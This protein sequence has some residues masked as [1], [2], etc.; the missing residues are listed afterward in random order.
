[1]PA[2]LP[3]GP[4]AAEVYDKASR[5]AA[6]LGDQVWPGYDFRKYARL[7]TDPATG[8]KAIRI[9]PAPKAERPDVL[10]TL[11]EAWLKKGTPEDNVLLAFHEGFH[12]FEHDPARPG[13]R[14]RFE[15]AFHLF[16]YAA[17]PARNSALFA[18]E[19]RLLHDA[20]LAESAEE[21]RKRARQ[22]LTVRGLRQK[23]LAAALVEFEKG[24]E[25]NE[26]MAEYAGARAVVDGMAAEK[27]KRIPATFSFTDGPR[28]V[29][30]KYEKL[31]SI[32]RLG[33]NG[34]LRFYYTGSA[35][36]LLLDRLSPAWKAALQEKATPVQELLAA[37]VGGVLAATE[38]E[39]AL[40]EARYEAVLREEE[41]EAKGRQEAAEKRLKSLLDQKGLRITINVAALGRVGDYS[42]FD[43]MNVTVLNGKRRLH[44]RMVN[45]AQKGLYRA[46]FS[47]PV[48]EDR[49]K[50]EY[51]TLVKADARPTATLDGAPLALDK[52][53]RKPIAKKLVIDAPQFHLEA[54]AGEVEV[55]EG[56]VVVT[57]KARAKE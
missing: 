32:T 4:K 2:A 28:Y 31:K 33:N 49:G 13:A 25:S 48:L 23:E 9:T 50:Q 42:S 36:G 12:A 38:A 20:M 52:P 1:L 57:L 5:L 47:Q 16:D 7:N 26:G 54:E 11:D 53:G 3:D 18:V 44:T 24:A 21:A 55:T 56:A 46:E 43:P 35:Q 30:E 45:V 37:A 14:W 29:R 51:V 40:R 8:E 41:D 27:E 19:A 17:L 6:A 39:A 34:R 22:F 10:I 15:N